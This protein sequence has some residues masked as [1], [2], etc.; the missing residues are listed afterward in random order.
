MVG[1]Q[2][3]TPDCLK[4][5]QVEIRK[6]DL[7]KLL[8]V[9][10]TAILFMPAVA[11]AEEIHVRNGFWGGIDAGAGYLK[12]SFDEPNEDDVYFFMGF[13]YGYTINPHLLPH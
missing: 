1:C 13:R 5:K 9:L 2:H 7:A 11:S 4:A 8:I 6:V 10:F 3:H 12:Q